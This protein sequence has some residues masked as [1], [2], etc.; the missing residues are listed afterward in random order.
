MKVKA[1]YQIVFEVTR[2]T[3]I[4]DERYAALEEHERRR[5]RD[6]S[7]ERLMPLWLESNLYEEDAKVFR[8]WRA[9]KPLPADF[10][11]QYAEVTEAVPVEGGEN[12]G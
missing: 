4:D 9:D 10:E 7:P 1:T 6:V 3:E 11:F 12:R 5:D 8:D 2:E